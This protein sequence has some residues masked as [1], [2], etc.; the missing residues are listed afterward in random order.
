MGLS[1][2]RLLI[3]AS[4]L[5]LQAPLTAAD[6]PIENEFS[7]EVRDGQ[8]CF[9][10][11]SIPDHPAG[12]FRNGTQ[13]KP[14]VDTLCVTTD[15]KRGSTPSRLSGAM[16][17]AL[18]GIQFKPNTS[19]FFDPD[20]DRGNSRHG[21]S[22]WSFDIAGAP[23]QRGLDENNAHVGKVDAYHYHSLPVSLINEQADQGSTLIGYAADG[24]EIHYAEDQRRSGYRLKEGK[25]P[26]ETDSGLYDGTYNEDYVFVGG[27]GLD[28][29]NMGMLDGKRVYFLTDN[30]P[31]VPRCLWGEPSEDFVRE[32]GRRN[33]H[34]N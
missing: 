16:G 2:F 18:N 15:P 30:Y 26:T 17:I 4:L 28:Q 27:T 20:A 34:S 9:T 22:A 5:L 14:N 21:D 25:R 19:G 31:F 24:F 11:N 7:M 23:N 8:R 33:R 32:R 29:C 12:P 1:F 13:V 6:T 3:S 10:T